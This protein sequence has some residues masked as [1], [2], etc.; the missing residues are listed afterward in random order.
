MLK[1]RM[2]MIENKIKT[3]EKKSIEFANL[4]KESEK[5]EIFLNEKTIRTIT[6]EL[7][8]L[9]LESQKKKGKEL[10]FFKKSI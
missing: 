10:D 7:T 5:I 8:L 3:L 1:S 4:T 6:K 9:S 2:E